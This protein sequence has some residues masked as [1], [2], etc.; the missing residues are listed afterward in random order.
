MGERE[1]Y[2]PG[3]FCWIDLGTSD[4]VAAKAF[5]VALFGWDAEDMPMGD[6]AVYTMLSRGG[7]H[8]CALY[9]WGDAPGLPAWM[10]YVSVADA[11]AAAAKARHAGALSVGEPFDVFDSGRMAIVQ[12]PT[13]AHV[14][15]WQP[16]NH[17]G[18]GVVNGPGA[19]CL[20]QLNST[21]PERA[22]RFYT[23]LLGWEFRQVG[24][25]RQQYWG[26]F[27]RGALNGG[28]MPV[29]AGAPGAS[30]WLVYFGVEDI[31]AAASRITEL[32]GRVIVPPMRIQS[33]WIAVALDPQHA[34]FALFA[35][36]F[37]E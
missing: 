21:D 2:E 8:V 37:D 32:G 27:N 19:W 16:R 18:A 6:G 25:D 12:D 4:A 33:G 35:G 5:Y 15:L 22:I 14:A 24:D 31:E 36:R 34:A 17:M 10:S 28:M 13:G 23:D 1:R 20:N 3:T 7:R 26:I 29:P 11:D 9:D 30:S